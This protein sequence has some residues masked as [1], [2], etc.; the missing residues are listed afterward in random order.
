M[1]ISRRKKK[2]ENKNEKVK[3]KDQLKKWSRN[4]W[5]KPSKETCF[6]FLQHQVSPRTQQIPSHL[7]FSKLR[8][9]LRWFKTFTKLLVILFI[10]SLTLKFN[11]LLKTCNL[12]VTVTHLHWKN[13]FIYWILKLKTKKRYILFLG[14]CQK[15][16]NS[17]NYLQSLKTKNQFCFWRTFSLNLKLKIFFFFFWVSSS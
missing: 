6:V 14:C 17:V 4:K 16:K 8:G 13:E 5:S 15:K 10:R 3:T 7:I 9:R 12:K 2:V 1:F 11:R